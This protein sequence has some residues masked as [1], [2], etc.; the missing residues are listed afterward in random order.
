MQKFLVV[1][2]EKLFLPSIVKEL[3]EN[4]KSCRSLKEPVGGGAAAPRSAP[5]AA[6][7]ATEGVETAPLSGEVF[8]PCNS[9]SKNPPTRPPFFPSFPDTPSQEGFEFAFHPR[10]LSRFLPSLLGSVVPFIALC[11]KAKLQRKP[12]KWDNKFDPSP[13][14]RL[15]EALGG[16]NPDQVL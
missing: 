10:P 14:E 6:S 15:I 13:A 5:S 7:A 3:M 12:Y 9:G 16:R 4:R 8:P 1:F 2:K 11:I